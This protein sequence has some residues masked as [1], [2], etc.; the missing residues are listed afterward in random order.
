MVNPIRMLALD[1]DGVVTD[2]TVQI[3]TTGEERKTI[4]FQDVDLVRAAARAGF[5]I[6]FITGEDNAMVAEIARR[7]GVDEVIRGAKDKLAAL[8]KLSRRVKVPLKMFCYVGDAD[9]DA[10][11]LAKVGL[12]LAPANARPSAKEAAHYVLRNRGGDGAVAEAVSLVLAGQNGAIAT[13]RGAREIRRAATLRL[14]EEREFLSSRAA[15]LGKIAEMV[16]AALIARRVMIF[17]ASPEWESRARSFVETLEASVGKRAA[18]L[19]EV[20]VDHGSARPSASKKSLPDPGLARRSASRG[21]LVALTQSAPGNSMAMTIRTA[22]KEG[23]PV[24]LFCEQKPARTPG[25][26]KEAVI[27]SGGSGQAQGR[28]Q[29]VGWEVICASLERDFSAA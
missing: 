7:F 8:K 24:V 22:Q 9:R 25:G 1:I 16:R 10:P 13:S 5:P 3:S 27:I 14:D 4:A 6:A 18:G 2:G 26:P 28:L 11:A 12:G 29:R 15:E 20:V 23:T 21:L 19:M 17:L